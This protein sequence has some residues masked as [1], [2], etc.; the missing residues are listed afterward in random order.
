[1]KDNWRFIQTDFG[2]AYANMA[3]D[4]AMLITYSQGKIP[5]T[6]RIY[7]WR[8]PAFSFGYFQNPEQVLDIAKCNKENMP[9]VRRITGGEVIFHH[10]ELTYSLVCSKD[11]IRGRD[12]VENS[13]KT[14]CLFLINTYKKLGLSPKFAIEQNPY[15]FKNNSTK[16]RNSFCFASKEKYDIVVNGKKLGGNAQRRRRNII[17]QHGSIPLKSDIDTAIP[18]LKEKPLELKSNTC[19]LQEVLGRGIEF[20]ELKNVIRNSFE[21]TFSVNLQEEV[22]IF[23][24]EK[25]F[26]EL[27]EEKYCSLQW[28][29][30]QIDNFRNS[31]MEKDDSF[32]QKTCL[33]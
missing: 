16:R 11:K 1:M 18:F 25:L 3:M 19:S 24:E 31:R 22:L 20:L 32:Y 30:H 8:P 10:Q 7:G 12:F 13:L 6:L 5:P 2:G 23:E 15:L 26:H 28:N 4:E 27:K 14:I 33:A 17:F 29:L 9:F 21:E